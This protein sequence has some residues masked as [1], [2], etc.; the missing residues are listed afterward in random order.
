VV[1][2]NERKIGEKGSEN[3]YTL[4]SHRVGFH[5]HSLRIANYGT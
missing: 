2:G 4:L 5:D 1:I 3:T